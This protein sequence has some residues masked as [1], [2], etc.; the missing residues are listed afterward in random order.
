MSRGDATTH[1]S[2]AASSTPIFTKEEAVERLLFSSSAAAQ[3]GKKS[4]GPFG[5]MY[6]SALGGI[7]TD[8]ALM[9]VPIDDHMVHRGHAVFDTALVKNGRLYQL[10]AHLDRLLRS[11]ASARIPLQPHTREEMRRIIIDTAAAAAAAAGGC[12]EDASVRYWLSVGTGGFGIS[13]KECVGGSSFYVMVFQSPPYPE[14]YYT[15]GM[16]VVTSTVPIKPPYLARLKS[17]NYLLNA[18]MVLEANDRGADNGIFIDQ[19]GCIGESS[20]MNVAF[21]TA[22][23]VLRCPRFDAILPGITVHRVMELA[24]EKLVAK[25]GA[26]L[27]DVVVEDIPAVKE[28]GRHYS[29]CCQE[30]MLVG[31]SIQVA[32]VVE[33]D[34]QPIGNGKPGPVAAKLLEL[35]KEDYYAADDQLI[36]LT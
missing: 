6:S 33:W 9:V 28:D 14:R 11:A 21:V 27:A 25:A 8:P 16:K 24:R 26:L 7:V 29:S 1:P 4:S 20:I 32:P 17:N 22:D 12:R 18:L 36:P 34:G 3:C 15:E 13:S 2:T 23:R 31:S 35:L 19:S 5:A 10:D 30:M